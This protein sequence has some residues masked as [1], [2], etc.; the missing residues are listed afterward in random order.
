MQFKKKKN[1]SQTRK[2]K[3]SYL[4][5]CVEELERM[6]SLVLS[7]QDQGLDNHLGSRTMQYK[8]LAKCPF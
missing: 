6:P 8:L 5:V 3:D 7:P 2:S 4:L 1:S